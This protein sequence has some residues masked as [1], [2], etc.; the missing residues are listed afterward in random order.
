MIVLCQQPTTDI[1]SFFNRA[2]VLAAGELVYFGE[3]GAQA[4]QLLAASGMPCPPLYSPLEQFMRLID[5]SFE[6][7]G[8]AEHAGS[9]L[10]SSLL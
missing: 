2:M 6:V 9:A 3:T 7:R 10:K 1:C 5:P 8:A 4:Q